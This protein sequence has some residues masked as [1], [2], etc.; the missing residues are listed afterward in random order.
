MHTPDPPSRSNALSRWRPRARPLAGADTSGARDVEASAFMTVA[1][2]AAKQSR[3]RER[4]LTDGAAVA[5]I[6]AMSKPFQTWTVLPHEP[7][8]ELG[9]D[10][11][12][13]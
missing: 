9:D 7:V 10:I 12:A 4:A 1:D 6:G 11:L 2:A 13:M 5:P 3:A 8:V